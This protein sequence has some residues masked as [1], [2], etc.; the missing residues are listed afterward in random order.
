MRLKFSVAAAIAIVA[1]L[2]PSASFAD[3]ILFTGTGGT[4]S[5]NGSVFNITGGG[6][7]SVAINGGSPVS[8]LNGV[9][10]LTTAAANP[11][12]VTG[13][14]GGPCSALFP[15]GGSLTVVG[16]GI[17]L[18]SGSYL[19]SGLGQGFSVASPNSLGTF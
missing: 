7:N 4:A 14:V 3:A 16:N 15:A 9:I 1:L 17:T 12:N 10:T 5:F 13:C 11:A 8:I 2:I 6:I 18:L 19:A